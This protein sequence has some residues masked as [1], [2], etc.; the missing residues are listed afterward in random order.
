[1]TIKKT[2]EKTRKSRKPRCTQKQHRSIEMGCYFSELVLGKEY[3]HVHE[4]MEGVRRPRK[5]TKKSITPRLK[6]GACKE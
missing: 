5:G 3:R 2:V 4:I 1:M 6:A